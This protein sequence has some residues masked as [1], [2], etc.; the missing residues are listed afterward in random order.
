MVF[1][2]C[3][4]MPS[5]QTKQYKNFGEY[6]SS[7]LIYPK[8]AVALHKTGYTYVEYIIEKDGSVSN[9]KI[10]K[11]REFFPS[12]DAEAIRVISNSPKWNPGMQNGK[13]IRVKQIQKISFN[14]DDSRGRKID[15]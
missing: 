4:V 7:H 11:G 5:F 10:I 13:A 6:V 3:E 15:Q 2:F 8:D 14:I 12:C 1:N 9:V